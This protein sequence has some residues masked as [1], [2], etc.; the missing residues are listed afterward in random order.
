[1]VDPMRFRSFVSYGDPDAEAAWV[2]VIDVN[3]CRIRRLTVDV[4]AS[5]IADSCHCWFHLH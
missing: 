3:A 4:D 2:R 5:V 1:M